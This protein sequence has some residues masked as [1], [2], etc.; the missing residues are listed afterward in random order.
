[1]NKKFRSV[2]CL[3]LCLATVLSFAACKKGE[4]IEPTGEKTAHTVQ[5]VNEAG[6]GLAGIGVYIYEDSTLAELVWYQATD[7]NGQISFTDLQ[8]STYVA[9][10]EDVPTG[11]AVQ[12][13]YALTG[14][15]TVITLSAGTMTGEEEDIVYKLGDMV[16]DFGFT[17]TDGND[18]TLKGLLK[19][20]QAVVL[21]FYFNGCQPCKMEFP[22]LQEAYEDYAHQIAVVAMNPMDSAEDVAAYQKEMDLSFLMAAVNPNWQNIMNVKAYPTTVVID[23]FGNIVLM[24][25][26]SIDNA[27]TFRDIFAA[28]TGED[29]EQKIYENI[30]EI[31]TT[32]EVGTA[33]NPDFMGP[34]PKFQVTVGAGKEYHIEFLKLKN[35]TMQVKDPD[36]YVIY[37]GEKHTPKNGVITLLVTCP[38]MNTPVTI[39]FGNSSDK[40]KTF[41]VTMASQPGTL[42]NPYTLKEGEVAVKIP[43]GNEQ[44]IYHIWI[45]PENGTLRAWCTSATAGVKY[46]CTLY[47]LTSYAQRSLSGEGITD[48][49]GNKCVEVKVNKGD[50]VQMI[51]A[52]MPDESWNYPAGTFV[53]QVKFIPGE[54]RDGEK[55]DKTTYTVTVTDAEDQPIANVNFSTVVQEETVNFATKADGIATVELPT[56]TYQVTMVVPEGYTCEV[57][58]FELT[59]EA[60][61]YTVKLEKKVVVMVDYTVIVTDVFDAPLANVTVIIGDQFANT[62]E[63]GKAV[64]NLEQGQYS[65]QVT[66]PEGYVALDSYDFAEEVTELTVALEYTPGTEN[67][68]IAI[69]DMVTVTDP[70]A[71]GKGVYYNLFRMGG[72]ILTV[73]DADAAITIGENT[74]EANAEGIVTFVVPATDSPM[75]PVTMLLTNRGAADK[76]FTITLTYPLGHRMNPQKL[77]SLGQL[78]TKLEENDDDGYFYSW[79]AAEEGVVTFYVASATG[80]AA[81]DISL[82]NNTNS[83]NRLLSADGQ[84]GMVTLNVAAGDSV[85][86]QVLTNAFNAD[87]QYVGHPETTIVSMGSFT[88][89]E[90]TE[91][92]KLIY[93]VIVKDGAGYP[94]PNVAVTIG[95]TALTTDNNGMAFVQLVEGT[96]TATVT[97]PED[98]YLT[99]NQFTLTPEMTQVEVMLEAIIFVDYQV[100]LLYNGSAYTGQV[101]VQI[102]QGSTVVHEQTVTSGSVAVSLPLEDYTVKLVIADEELTYDPASCNLSAGDPVLS[103]TLQKIIK[104]LN[105]TV[106]VVNAKNEPQTGVLVQIQ[107][108]G[109]SV[110][111]GTGTTNASGVFTAKLPGDN[112]TVNLS[113]SGVSCYYNKGTAVLSAANTSLTIVLASEVDDN[114]V[115]SHWFIEDQNMYNLYE[116]Y[117]HIRVGAGYPYNKPVSG[118]NICFFVYNP[119]RAGSFRFVLDN[120]TVELMYYGTTN[121]P[122]LNKSSLDSETKDVYCNVYEGQQG[123]FGIVLGVAVNQG[124]TD[125]GITISRVGEPGFNPNYA[126][127]DEQWM[128]GAITPVKFTLPSGTLT[129][130]DIFETDASKYVAVYN[131]ED[132]CYHLGSAD[133]PLLYINLGTVTKPNGYSVNAN[134]NGETIDGIT[135]GGGAFQKYFYD[136]NGTFLKK[137]KYNDLMNA[138]I[139]CVDTKTG[140]YPATKDLVYMIQNGCEGQWLQAGGLLTDANKEL[141]WM[142]GVCY[143]P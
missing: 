50:R 7:D 38:D 123:N 56:D 13:Q 48:E 37:K 36:A 76:S 77:E 27:Q 127:Y 116:G 98:Y 57:T 101:L 124:I 95:T 41:T 143:I 139:A 45:A 40:E 117:T 142:F 97:P 79:T 66:A 49:E 5:V 126:P 113:F 26:G 110:S 96:Y 73:A 129:Y 130:V 42:D 138:Y 106:S 59:K 16:M 102:L 9:V 67:N 109:A 46:D 75:M 29:Y 88:A 64:F 128:E 28:V 52:V 19:N 119:D 11:Y 61:E 114:D 1:M 134:I 65:V 94:M 107:K 15:S 63:Q 111:G 4:T 54:G 83:V 39:V 31:E 23:R 60:P 92:T 14:L 105:Y 90:N 100:N 20:K 91:D 17:A 18:Y 120:P 108:A 132:G 135:V 99:D 131:A 136:E 104:E 10:L 25:T 84:S 51:A 118:K 22:Y 34:Q 74:Y 58:E 112:Y 62:D 137:E 47:N 30:T 140:V 133:G 8:R 70:I 33:E 3:L 141:A 43:A 6:N 81:Y 55:E 32:A 122:A 93:S 44:G 82:T 24:H 115:T 12:E 21:N 78:T 69:Y 89:Q 72:L 68:P 35:L 80:D 87:D 121:W 2:L 125:L 86:I 71:A 53:Y 85:S 103:I